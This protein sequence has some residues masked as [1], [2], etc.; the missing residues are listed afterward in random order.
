MQYIQIMVDQKVIELYQ[1]KKLLLNMQWSC[2][3]RIFKR[4][5]ESLQCRNK[6]NMK[7]IFKEFLIWVL[8]KL[9]CIV[10]VRKKIKI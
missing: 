7:E 4:R 6:T 2:Q 3:W 5:Y 9:I 8:N 10:L 1:K